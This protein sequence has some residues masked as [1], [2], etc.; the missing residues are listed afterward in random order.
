MVTVD[1]RHVQR[2]PTHK[3]PYPRR[4]LLTDTPTRHTRRHFGLMAAA[5]ASALAF[6]LASAV[7]ASAQPA[8]AMAPDP[9]TFPYRDL[10]RELANKMAGTYV[11]TTTGDLLIQEHR[12]ASRRR[13]TRSDNGCSVYLLSGRR[14]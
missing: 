13:A 14:A 11:I 3:K 10:T 8:R 7:A 2:I 4:D 5:S 12:C 6:V 1:E 9:A